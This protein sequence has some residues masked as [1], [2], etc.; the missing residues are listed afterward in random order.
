L[1]RFD[2]A[3]TSSIAAD[4]G[5][6][7]RALGKRLAR[8]GKVAPK[9]AP[10]SNPQSVAKEKEELARIMESGPIQARGSN[11]NNPPQSQQTAELGSV[12]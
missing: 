4:A 10:T 7:E 5:A 11:K 2:D 6:R 12:F 9:C 3:V 8:S 1:A